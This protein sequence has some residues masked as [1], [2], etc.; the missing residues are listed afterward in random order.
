MTCDH[1]RT[2]FGRPTGRQRYCCRACRNKARWQR[3]KGTPS[4]AAYRAA[5]AAKKAYKTEQQLKRE[6]YR[7]QCAATAWV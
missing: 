3:A 2:D 1:C 7:Q 5:Q 4:V 6:R